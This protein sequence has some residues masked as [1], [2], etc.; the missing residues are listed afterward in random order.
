MEIWRDGI[1]CEVIYIIQK[2][3]YTM[4]L[5][6]KIKI[7]IAVTLVVNILVISLATIFGQPS[8]RNS[9]QNAENTELHY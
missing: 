2:T 4:I 7:I 1:E 8:E 5:S 6:K 9:A 3:P